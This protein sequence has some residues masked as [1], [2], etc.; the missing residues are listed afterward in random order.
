MNPLPPP[1][2]QNP[3]PVPSQP[4]SDGAFSHAV[5]V[6]DDNRVMRSM[7][8]RAVTL[9]GLPVSR[10]DSAGNGREALFKLGGG[11]FNLVLLDIN[12]PVMDGE[13]FLHALRA[14]PRLN[15]TK[16][17]V[18]STESSP[19]RIRSLRGLGA[20]FIHKPFRPEE[21]IAAVGRLSSALPTRPGGP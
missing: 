15:A 8:S 10:I 6:V 7:I 16:V 19:A 18:V 14:D 1:A 5:L 11:G 20:D 2:G 9:S 4:L 21:L 17:V 3:G 13:Q 12:M